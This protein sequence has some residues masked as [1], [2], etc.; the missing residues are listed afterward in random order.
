MSRPA[1]PYRFALHLTALAVPSVRRADWLAEWNAELWYICRSLP[2]RSPLDL[3]HHRAIAGFCGGAIEDAR[4][5]RRLHPSAPTPA[6]ASGISCLFALLAAALVAVTLAAALPGVHRALT[7]APYTSSPG[8]ATIWPAGRSETADPP[9]RLRTLRAWQQ[10]SQHLFSAFAFYQPIVKPVHIDAHHAPELHIARASANFITL[11][12]APITHAVP[13]SPDDSTPV[14]L[15]SASIWHSHFAS[16]TGIFGQTIRVSLDRARIGGVVPDRITPDGSPIDAWLLLPEA[17]A[18]AVP[19]SARVF[20]LAQTAPHVRSSPVNNDR[21]LMSVS[22]YD[23]PTDDSVDFDC[24]ALAAHRSDIVHS[25]LFT[26]FLALLSLPATASLSLGEPIAHQAGQPWRITLRRRLFLFAKFALL[27]PAVHFASLD[28]AY[29]L[30]FT[31]PRSSQ[32]VH[33]V[34]SFCGMLFAL[35]W[36]LRDQRRRCPV[37]LARLGFPARVGEPSRN[38]LT[39]NGTELICIGGHG[40]LHVPEHSTSWF[41]TPR[42]LHL[43]PSWSGLFLTPI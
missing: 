8:V 21:W 1:T 20:V 10:R 30:P 32:S 24:I 41:S 2:R 22:A 9:I 40:L 17:F 23:G 27:L 16:R 19:G 6:L 42:W 38:F 33:L 18:T 25:A 14:L 7:P 39:W 34:A 37:C 31:S 3:A 12:G 13:A 26:L 5:L 36:V 28:L 4:C 43:D 35:R 11:L 15:L 29:G